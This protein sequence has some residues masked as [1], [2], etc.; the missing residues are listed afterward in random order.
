M[1][2]SVS[3]YSQIRFR[4]II[5]ILLLLILDRTEGLTDGL[6]K[7]KTQK[8]TLQEKQ[9]TLKTCFVDVN[10]VYEEN[11]SILSSTKLD[12]GGLK[13]EDKENVK[14][15]P[16]NLHTFP[17]IEII[18]ITNCSVTSV[19]KNH[20]RALS[21][22]WFLNLERNK[23][24]NIASD[25]FTDLV[26][27]E[28]LDL[29]TNR[30]QSLG[31]NIFSSLKA[32]KRLYLNGNEI[33]FLN[34]QI[35]ASLV[36][37][38]YITMRNNEITSLDENIFES[39]TSFKNISLSNNKLEKIPRNLFSYNSKIE[40]IW[41]EEN[42]IKFIDVNIFDH[43]PNLKQVKMERNLCVN[44]NYDEMAFETMRQDLKRNCNENA[45]LEFL[46]TTITDLHS[47]LDN[48]S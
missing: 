19:S 32:L 2:S 31:K 9:Q 47:K 26:S 35:F 46:E 22:L 45:Y 14:F 44:K 8:I 1:F 37:V 25:A 15:L 36:N 28:I 7:I 12:I 40:W 38:E 4:W 23:I 27:L 33:Q 11:F 41:L 43:L 18:Q 21:K 3:F 30:I 34:S 5:G 39:L 10:E 6:C 48:Q 20:F 13:L 24:E 42:I 16:N 29:S 17:G